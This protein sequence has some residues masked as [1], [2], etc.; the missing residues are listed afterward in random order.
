MHEM[1]VSLDALQ[2][3]SAVEDHTA[4][5]WKVMLLNSLLIDD[6]LSND[7]AGAKEDGSGDSL[8]EK[9]P[10]DQLGLVP[11]VKRSIGE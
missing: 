11:I 2:H 4:S 8:G 3:T 9:G 7:I 6:L 10:L 5:P 1:K